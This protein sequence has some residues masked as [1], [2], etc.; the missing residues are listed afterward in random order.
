MIIA[1]GLISQTKPPHTLIFG[2]HLSATSLYNYDTQDH[3]DFVPGR[4]LSCDV[5]REKESVFLSSGIFISNYNYQLKNNVTTYSYV[6]GG[7]PPNSSHYKGY[8]W[9]YKGAVVS[10]G[11]RGSLNFRLSN[12]YRKIQVIIGITGV[13]ENVVYRNLKDDSYIKYSRDGYP[14]FNP[15]TQEEGYYEIVEE[16]EFKTS[17]VFGLDK[18]HA[19]TSIESFLRFTSSNLRKNQFGLELKWIKHFTGLLGT[20]DDYKYRAAPALG[21]VWVRTMKNKQPQKTTVG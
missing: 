5:T 16:E 4:T 20:I 19:G 6:D 15:W 7:A 8:R 17:D 1:G 13:F 11:I 3:L 12:D 14:T 9:N 21:L 18:Y 2:L 10:L